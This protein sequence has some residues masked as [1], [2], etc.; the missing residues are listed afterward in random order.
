MSPHYK[1]TPK[2]NPGR[3]GWLIEFRHPLRKDTN[4]KPGRKIRKGLGTDDATEAER[5]AEQLTELL[6]NESLWSVGGKAEAER[7]FDPKVIE[8]FYEEFTGA[9]AQLGPAVARD[10]FLTMPTAKEGYAKVA[11]M[12]VP[13]A[14]KTTLM[15]QLM[16]T[17]PEKER[18]PST[19]VNRTTTF[20]TEVIL[21]AEGAYEAAVTFMSEHQVRFS[22]EECLSSAIVAAVD[23][24]RAKVATALLEK[25]DMRFRLKYL[26]GDYTQE[27]D[28][29]FDPYETS[30]ASPIGDSDSMASV[31]D[32]EKTQ[33]ES[34]LLSY[35]ERIEALTD[36]LLTKV[37]QEMGAISS[38]APEDR[39]AALDL[40]EEEATTTDEFVEL[41]A[42]I[43]EEIKTKFGLVT[44]GRFEKTTTGW[45]KA[46]QIQKNADERDGFIR[47]LRLFSG[48]A[49]QSWGKLLTPLVD[50]LRV[51]GPFKPKWATE[52][53]RLVL[54]DTEGLGHKAG[55]TADLPESVLTLLHESDV[56][57]LVDS[58]KNGMTNFATG[59][60][61]E[62]VTNAG[63]TRKLAV[64]FT[65]MDE[66]KGDNLKGRAKLDHVF[67]GLRNVVE[68]QLAKNVSTEA[69]RHL[70][71]H[72]RDQATPNTFYVG[73]V[74]RGD[75][76]PAIPQLQAMLAR[77]CRGQPAVFEPMAFPEYSMD[78]LV[79]AIQ[80]A[81][82][83]FR[84]QWRGLLGL[85]AHH[86]YKQLHWQSVKA[87]SR[88]YAEGWDDGYQLQPTANLVAALSAAASRF[89][90]S[91]IS[92]SGNPTPDEKRETIDLIKTAVTKQLPTLSRRRL[93][94]ES[95]PQWYEAYIV[96]GKGSARQRQL[97][98]EGIYELRVPVPD[99]RGDRQVNEFM[100][101]VKNIV[102]RA[103]KTVEADVK[104]R[105]EAK[106]AA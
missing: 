60:A 37:E 72:L 88:R 66:V 5:L 53:P 78:N 6:A 1:A 98:I 36:R 64:V 47:V 56:I 3:K 76:Q 86:E 81:A 38:M 16:G 29:D 90:E 73:A 11:L 18:F 25:S 49:V 100:T 20:P 80:E 43:L 13:G 63:H 59:K 85:I 24:E 95:Q 84:E 96:R 41:V 92:W 62:A 51:A 34:R 35:L 57:L 46:W 55:S 10:K 48:I 101:E 8:V 23:G 65:H 99:S 68:N 42:D 105:A 17:D 26:L 12:G 58:A 97:E 61:L 104:Q 87:L 91:P 103:I 4:G 82:R 28:S 50:G 30:A 19:S 14:G 71:D 33:F 45:P 54:V 94:D 7:R 9:E 67:G 79:L 93:R 31:S 2:Q 75:P 52:T 32:A 77:L 70:L 15:R 83:D 102:L 22:V 44:E 27:D 69:A 39:S 40:I 106:P 74:D 89:L 21:R